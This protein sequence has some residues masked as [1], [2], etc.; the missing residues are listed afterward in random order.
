MDS[1]I[2]TALGDRVLEVTSVGDGVLR[3]RKPA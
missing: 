2:M 3:V 1:R